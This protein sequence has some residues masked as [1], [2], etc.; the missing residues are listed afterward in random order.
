M[1]LEL[2]DL[3]L[4][5]GPSIEQLDSSTN[6]AENPQEQDLQTVPRFVTEFNLYSEIN[7]GALVP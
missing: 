2:R 3:A 7:G 1:W 4:P 6:I 5:E